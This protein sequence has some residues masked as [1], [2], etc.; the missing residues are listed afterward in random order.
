MEIRVLNYF[1][2]IVREGSVNKAASVLHITQPTLSRQIA[3]LESELGVTLFERSGRGLRLTESGM[4]LQRRAEE[5]LSLVE[6]TETEL[7]EQDTL[8]EG[9]IVIGSGELAAVEHMA[10][11]MD[12]FHQ[13]YPR[14]QFEIETAIGSVIKEK[15]ER[16][17]IDVGILLEPIDIET[18]D[19]LRFKDLERWVV[20]M[21]KDDPLVDKDVITPMDLI[22]SPI[23]LPR[24]GEVRNEVENW[25]GDSFSELDVLFTSNLSTNGA[26]LVQT[27]LARSIVIEGGV[28]LFSSDKIAIKRLS[29]DLRS[30]S[31]IVWKKHVSNQL[32]MSKF[33]SFINAYKA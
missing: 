14:V 26:K 30:S 12:S 4:L 6:R 17:L 9:K 29:P 11:I 15:M 16:G 28:N 31:V 23:I 22:D 13:A 25:F 18:F 1:L 3:A 21:S 10:K 19:F 27:G 8:V 7:V 24:R 32:A 5:I 33:I 20:L 2:T